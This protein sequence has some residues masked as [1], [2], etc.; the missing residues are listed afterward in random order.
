MATPRTGGKAGGAPTRLPI[1]SAVLDG[2]DCRVIDLTKWCCFTLHHVVEAR[3]AATGATPLLLSAERG[4]DG[5]AR[6]LLDRGASVHAV[7]N[8]QQTA[9]H[10]AAKNGHKKYMELLLAHEG[11]LEVR[12]E[13]LF[14]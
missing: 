5:V 11:D 14:S 12:G 10:L 2:D 7:D 4:D 9:L 6:I 3:D 8:Q 13:G 1:H